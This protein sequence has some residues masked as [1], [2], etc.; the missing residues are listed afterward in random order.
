[1]NTILDV[2]RRYG[3]TSQDRVLSV[4]R[5]SFDLSVYDIFGLLS[6]GGTVVVPDEDERLEPQS[7]LTLIRA[8]GVTLW[9]TVPALGQILCDAVEEENGAPL[10]LKLA[11]FSGDWIPRDLPVKL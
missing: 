5:L 4:S 7:W 2:S 6:A 10:P 8:H 3:V 11:I 1:M 9:N